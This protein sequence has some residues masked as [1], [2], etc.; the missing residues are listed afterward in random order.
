MGPADGRLLVRTGRAGAAARAGHDLLIEVESW[1]ASLVVDDAAQVTSVALR[2]DGASLRV[3]EGSGGIQ[4]LGDDDKAAIKQTIDDDV[5]R[6]TAIEFRSTAVERGAAGF[7]VRG[8]L[9]LRGRRA[10]IA[11]TLALGDGGRLRGSASVRQT[12]FGIKPYSALFGTLKVAD[13]VQVTVDA[14][15]GRGA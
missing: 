15:L 7:E 13:E 1:S 6:A 5:L 3:L 14:T 9:E 12:A 11:F 10:P 2:A 8:E 4:S